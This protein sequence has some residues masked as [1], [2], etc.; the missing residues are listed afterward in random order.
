MAQE[1]INLGALADDGT[2]DTI[3]AT[4]IKINNNFTELYA[5]P[6]AQTQLGFVENEISSTQSNADIVLKPS[7]TGAILFPAI[8]INDN[9]IEGTRTNEDLILR[10]NGSGSLVVGGIGIAGTSITALDSSF[11]N[12]NEDLIVDGTLTT[13]G[14]VTVSGTVGSSTGS[15]IG[16]ITLANGSITDSSGAISFGD[17]DLT[18]TA[19]SLA[20]NGTLTVANGS[21]TDSSGAISFGNENITTTG[22]IARATGSTI[23]NLTLGNGSITDS[24][25]SISFGNEDLTTTATSLAINGTLT[26]ANG[27]ITDSS[28]SIS[29]GNEDVTTTGTIAGGTGSTIG[30]LTLGN[31]SI[32]DSGG[33]ISF[34]NE[35]IT[36]TGTLSAETGSVIG[37]KTFA[38]G[39]ITDSSG[40]ISFSDENVTTTGTLDVS[41]LATIGSMATVS[42]VSSFVGTITV[43]NLTFN[44]NIIASS[45]NADINLTPGGTGVVNV[46]NL[47][48]DSSIN[49]KDNVIKLIRSDDDFVLSAN[50][51]GSVQISKIDMNEGTVDNTVIGATTPAAGTFTTVSITVPSVNAD[52]V[53]ITDNKIKAT[54]TDANLVINASGSGNVI[55]NG[56]TFPNT[57]V[58]GQLIRTNGSK[59]LSTHIFPFVV[60]D[61]DVQDAT[62]TITGNSSTQVI[63]SFA[64]ATYRSVKYY[65][66][67]SDATADRY[68]LIEANVTHDGT[69]AFVSSFGAATNG[70]GDGSTIY[71]SIDLSADI[72]GG[73][74]R[75][76]GTVNNT[77]NQV[78]KLVRRVIKV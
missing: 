54:D 2:G 8:R 71:D 10:A 76:L 28:G 1:L 15:G 56:F 68:T 38:D 24:S 25:G 16:T 72:N 5:L 77:N 14:N 47:T 75:L 4:G 60:T 70:D 69:N 43:D 50:G 26:V 32:T 39:S 67:I 23:G 11:V 40:E 57:M 7:G 74:V 42:G 64:A 61:T 51:T 3:R 34:G 78:I 29:F 12:I 18:T 30:A 63:N 33:S 19:T 20:I 27:S 62:V 65:I 46:S 44:D 53:N 49:L 13:T 41:G 58:G 31:G 55:I 9:N 6:F 22:T 45:S 35:N 59:V 73:N 37:N 17:E 21:I 66:Q 36:T 48:I 52:K